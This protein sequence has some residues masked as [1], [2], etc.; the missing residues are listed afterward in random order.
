[1]KN[2]HNNLYILFDGGRLSIM[3]CASDKTIH[4]EMDMPTINRLK[5]SVVEFINNFQ[6]VDGETEII[7]LLDECRNDKEFGNSKRGSLNTRTYNTLVRAF[8]TL[9]IQYASQVKDHHICEFWKQRNFG[10]LAMHTLRY[11]L[12]K[13]NL[14]T[15]QN[16]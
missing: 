5:K 14:N 2:S 10:R 8:Q 3:D 13:Y 15:K 9:G 11:F 12:D 4:K 16:L 7:K 1:M 6:M